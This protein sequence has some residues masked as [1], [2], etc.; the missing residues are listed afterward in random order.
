MSDL[1][2]HCGGKLVTREEIDAIAMPPQT[3]TYYP[4]S[5]GKMIDHIRDRA[6]SLLGL[7]ILSEQ[8]GMNRSGAQFF[9]A[10]TLDTGEESRGLTFG[11]RNSLD[12]SLRKGGAAGERVFVCDNLAF[13]GSDAIYTRKHTRNGWDDFMANMDQMIMDSTVAYARLGQCWSLLKAVDV[14]KIEGYQIL[15]ELAG[16]E[17]IKPQQFSAAVADWRNPPAKWAEIVDNDVNFARRNMYNLYQCVTEGLKRGKAGD[18]LEN[19]TV[20]H[21]AFCGTKGMVPLLPAPE[22][23][24]A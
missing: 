1:I 6:T 7:P 4:I 15:G 19:H 10:I 20:V 3:E 12:K 8:Y 18:I 13:N 22:P 24:L 14:D 17:V 23:A 5:H 16:E 2:L 21:D 9:G 11:M